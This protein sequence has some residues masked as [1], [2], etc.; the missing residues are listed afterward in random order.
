MTSAILLTQTTS[1]RAP[2]HC[3]LA[4]MDDEAADPIPPARDGLPN[5]RVAVVEP[6]AEGGLSHF[7]ESLCGALAAAGIEVCLYTSSRFDVGS[8]SR[9]YSVDSSMRLWPAY[10]TGLTQRRGLR[11]IPRQLFSTLRRV[12]RAVRYMTESWRVVGRVLASDPDVVQLTRGDLNP[13]RPLNIARLRRSG[14]LV[15][16]LVHEVEDRERRPRPRRQRSVATRKDRRRRPHAHFV[17]SEYLGER[18]LA[19]GQ[20]R[21]D[22]LK[23]IPFGTEAISSNSAVPPKEIRERYRAVDRPLVLV[24]GTIRPSKGIPVL[25][26]AVARIPADVDFSLVIA[27]HPVRSVDPGGLERQVARLG[28]GDRVC[29]DFRYLPS[30]ELASLLDVAALVVLPYLSATQSAALHHAVGQGVPVLATRVGGLGSEIEDGRDGCLVPPGDPNALAG[31]LERLL[32][33]PPALAAM[34]QLAN[35]RF[36][37]TRGWDA[38]AREVIA[39]YQAWLPLIPTTS[40]RKR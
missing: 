18:L 15:V 33:D 22:R 30:D 28:I 11:R 24:F 25:L 2:P 34:G 9:K 14:S 36:L 38:T 21:E 32:K 27:G 13:L 23:V 16:E 6:V 12:R 3:I 29:F 17:M 10:D 40:S 7:A 5:L 39:G 8:T 26:D 20:A 4:V 19:S 35:H 37:K 31:A 1:E